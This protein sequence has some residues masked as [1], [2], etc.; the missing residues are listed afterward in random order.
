MT[1][2]NQPENSSYEQ[3]VM[4]GKEE[5]G[6]RRESRLGTR[7]TDAARLL[8]EL[9]Y[10]DPVAIVDPAIGFHTKTLRMF[11][12]RVAPRRVWSSRD[13]LAGRNAVVRAAGSGSAI[14][15]R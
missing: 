1:E 5:I 10:R 8:E 11:M 13:R 4:F 14:A 2:A 3:A 7:G 12:N 15:T 9:D 6:R